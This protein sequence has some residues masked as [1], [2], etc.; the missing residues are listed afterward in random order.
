MLAVG[1]M[2]TLTL[3]ICMLILFYT[4]ESLQREQQHRLRADP[5]RDAA[6]HRVAAARQGAREHR[7]SGV[8]VVLAALVGC[9]IVLLVQGKVPFDLGPFALRLGPAADA[10]PS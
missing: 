2:N 7:R 10:R 1:S 4:I 6:P 5:L 8:A 9:A 3:L